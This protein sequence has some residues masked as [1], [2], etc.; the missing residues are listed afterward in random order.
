MPDVIYL[1]S[2]GQSNAAPDSSLGGLPSTTQVAVGLNTLFDQVSTGEAKSG[3]VFYRCI[4]IS[5]NTTNDFINVTNSIT[6]SASNLSSMK[7]GVSLSNEVQLIS[8]IGVPT[9]GNFQL[10][11]AINVGGVTVIQNTAVIEWTGN[12]SQNIQEAINLLTY[13]SGVIIDN[14]I[15]SGGVGFTVTFSGND[16]SRAQNL[17]EIVNSTVTGITNSSITR[18]TGGGPI[19]Q[20]AASTGYETQAPYSVTF[21]G[22]TQ[23]GL[24]RSGDIYGLWIQ[25]N[26]PASTEATSQIQN[27]AAIITSYSKILEPDVP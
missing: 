7:I 15:I 19:N 4:Y 23:I 20:V 22:N 11:Y 26:T 25:R 6:Q 1:L 9:G 24:L 17:L 8:F 14:A 5:N 27:Q 18:V 13:L 21:G 12:V 16:G 3:G 2:G 10:R